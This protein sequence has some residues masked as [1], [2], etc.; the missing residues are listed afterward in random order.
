[1]SDVLQIT[2][3]GGIA[4]VR[5]N[6]PE[7][8]NALNMELFGALL[9][10]GEELAEDRSL[11]A[12][13]L[14]GNGPSFCSGLDA[15]AV[16]GDPKAFQQCF[17]REEGAEA[18]WVQKSAWVWRRLPVPV[19]AAVHGNCFGGGI[20]LA[21]AADLRLGA[22]DA[23]LSVMEIRWGLIPDV[24]G[25]ATL[26]ELVRADVARELCYTGRIVEASEAASLGLLTRIEA[27][28]LEA[29]RAMAREIAG[30]NPDAIR[31]GKRLLDANW[32]EPDYGV[33][34]RREQELQGALI[35]KPNQM[36]A[37]RAAM[38]K[39]PPQFKDPVV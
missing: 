37:V 39:T 30:K 1:M 2:R 16:M 36:E 15:P 9:Q 14:A 4:E 7:K 17:E 24:T 34:L 5:L 3:E 38:T 8:H 25:T 29:A 6:R 10:A 33:V 23:R 21:L 20:Q 32:Q 31:L 19:I 26:R 11:R 13:V 28:P 35:G 18:N 27:D 22:A 12:V